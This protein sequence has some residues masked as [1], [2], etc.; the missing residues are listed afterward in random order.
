MAGMS[1]VVFEALFA[2][3]VASGLAATAL[4]LRQQGQDNRKVRRQDAS[5]EDKA[6]AKTK[7]YL[8]RI[9]ASS[10]AKEITW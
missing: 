8:A 2:L 10:K 7:H 6:R 3:T 5:I 9:R 1:I 4:L